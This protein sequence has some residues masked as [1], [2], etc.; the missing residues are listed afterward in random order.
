MPTYNLL[1]PKKIAP[2]FN[3]IVGVFVSNK[4]TQPGFQFIVDIIDSNTGIR[5]DRKKQPQDPDGYGVFKLQSL[6]KNYLTYDFQPLATGILPAP[7]SHI[8]YNLNFGEEYLF[9]WPFGSNYNAGGVLGFSST[10][11]HYFQVGDIV[12]VDQTSG[13]TNPQYNGVHTVTDVPDDFHVVLDIAYATPT[14]GEPGTIIYADNSKTI[15]TGSSQ[16]LNNPTMQFSAASDWSSYGPDGC[17]VNLG[18]NVSNVL[19]FVIPDVSCGTNLQTSTNSF[20]SFVPGAMYKVS[21]NIAFVNNPSGEFEYVR[22]KLG[23]TIGNA[24]QG[25]GYTEQYLICGAGT[26]FG[27]E[28]FMDADTAGFGSHAIG[29]DYCSVELVNSLSGFT[30]WNAAYLDLDWITYN[31]SSVT[32]GSTSSKL[33]L[34]I[35]ET[36]V[37]GKNGY[38]FARETDKIVANGYTTDLN[39]AKEIYVKTKNDNG[40]IIGEYRISSP[41]TTNF[42]QAGIGPAN[43]SAS[44]YT[45]I[46]GATSIINSAM[47]SYDVF[48]ADIVDAPQSFTYTINI[49]RNCSRFEYIELMFLDRK[50]SFISYTF[51]LANRRNIGITRDDF[52]K[53]KGAY[54]PVNNTWNY[55]S[56][57]AGR[58]NYKSNMKESLTVNSDWMSETQAYFLSQ[59]FSSPVVYYN[60]QN[61]GVYVP[62]IC[63][64]SN[65]EFKT[66]Q[67][68]RLIQYT[69]SFDSANPSRVQEF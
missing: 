8:D 28:F 44:T 46:S 55:A 62:V 33:M 17:G 29:V 12:N 16:L 66:R 24:F 2:V 14:S 34:N 35:P 63:T 42:F 49:N 65:Y 68:Q 59:L 40:T 64:E 4:Q 21:Y 27:L 20:A 9:Y 15:F 37:V 69:M 10:T 50:G 11:Q 25:T 22:P 47:T 41:A 61:T 6:L 57:D 1:A 32:L 39:K 43:L 52:K 19:R 7:K 56:T 53:N 54:N 31:P 5:L 18:V 58:T 60:V 45:V 23:G 51:T 36:S 67:N 26:T 30:A 13:V 3:P 38:W 48:I